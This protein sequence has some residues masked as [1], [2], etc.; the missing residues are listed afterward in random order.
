MIKEEKLVY[1]VIKEDDTTNKEIV[2]KIKQNNDRN[3]YIIH[4]SLIQQLSEQRQGS[5]CT[6]TRGQ[7]RGGGKKPWKQ[8]GTGRARAGSI[9]SPL[10][11]GGGVIFGPAT[12]NYAQK[13]NKKEKQLALRT[14]IYNKFRD[15][16]VIDNLLDD[17]QEPNTKNIINQL[18]KLGIYTNK[19]ERILII[20]DKKN[21]NLFLSV[22]N[23]QNIEL[24]A[25]NQ[26]NV[27][28]IIK[29][30]K[31]LITINGLNKINEIYNG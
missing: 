14:L 3:M 6:K 2:F 1:S 11:R 18:Q 7:V 29:A 31:L 28:S 23:L 24:I 9:R 20:V 4:R 16:L 10:W 30:Q 27:L 22:R 25:A 12:R 5:A 13:I 17:L 26:L 8:K 21:K 19:K 15:T